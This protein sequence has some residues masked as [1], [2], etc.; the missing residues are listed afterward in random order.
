MYTYI[1]DYESDTAYKSI[2]ETVCEGGR[3]TKKPLLVTS[4]NVHML[5]NFKLVFSFRIINKY[6]IFLK[7]FCGGLWGDGVGVRVFDRRSYR[8][9]STFVV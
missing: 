2:V 7:F 6:D 1:D 8:A 3:I 5:P 4:K 9:K